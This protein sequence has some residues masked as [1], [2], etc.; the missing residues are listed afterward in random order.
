MDYTPHT[1]RHKSILKLIRM[2]DTYKQLKWIYGA[3]RSVNT[4]KTRRRKQYGIV[5]DNLESILSP[6]ERLFNGI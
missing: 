4:G 3:F 2:N 1:D 6:S 5:P